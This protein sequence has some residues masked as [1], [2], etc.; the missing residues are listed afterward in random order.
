MTKSAETRRINK[1]IHA[2]QSLMLTLEWTTQTLTTALTKSGVAVIPW[3]ADDFGALRIEVLLP[4]DHPR[5]AEA[6][7]LYMRL[8][9]KLRAQTW[10]AHLA[11]RTAD[12][13]WTP[14]A[15]PIEVPVAVSLEAQMSEIMRTYA[16]LHDVLLPVIGAERLLEM[17]EEL[18]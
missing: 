4:T 7:Q 8:E 2:W 3:F 5:H 15:N 6:Y 10:T 12:G 14:L 18:L 17:Q 13:C 16:A 1:N 9:L 11:E